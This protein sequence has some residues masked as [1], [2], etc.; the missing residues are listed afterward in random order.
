[1][2]NAENLDWILTTTDYGSQKYISSVQKG[3][4]FA[5]QFHPEK[6]GRVGIE[7]IKSFLNLRGRITNLSPSSQVS[8]SHI[9]SLP[10]TSLTRRIVAC[11]DVRTNDDGDLVVTKGEQYDVRELAGDNNKR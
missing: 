2:P 1:M 10:V 3:N 6:S 7:M 4:I 9:M 8:L 11:L 5:V